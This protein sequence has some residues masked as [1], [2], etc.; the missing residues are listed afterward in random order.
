M[1]YCKTVFLIY[2]SVS[3]IESVFLTEVFNLIFDPTSSVTASDRSF[4]KEN[5]KT[6]QIFSLDLK[7]CKMDDFFNL[8]PRQSF[9]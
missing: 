3:L 9:L 6:N 5:N 1:L 2:I 7:A 8:I 4:Y